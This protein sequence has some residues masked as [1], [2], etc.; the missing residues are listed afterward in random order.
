MKDMAE[1]T[2][3]A[4]QERVES[5]TPRET[6]VLTHI[7]EGFTSREDRRHAGDQRQDGRAPPREHQRPSSTSTTASELVKFAIRKGLIQP[8][9]RTARWGVVCWRATRH[10]S[11][12][13]QRAVGE[14]ER[15]RGA[16]LF[17]PARQPAAMAVGGRGRIRSSAPAAFVGTQARHPAGDIQR[18]RPGESYAAL[19]RSC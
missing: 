9:M 2:P 19:R 3:A 13:F 18:R 14:V 6:E 16:I 8:E 5:L 4:S 17:R 11:T 15:P 12:R 1:Q 7:A 10:S